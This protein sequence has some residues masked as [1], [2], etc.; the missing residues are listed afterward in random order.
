MGERMVVAGLSVCSL[1]R[2]L[3]LVLATC[4]SPKQA[5]FLALISK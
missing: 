2:V 1:L 5:R 4:A 3:L